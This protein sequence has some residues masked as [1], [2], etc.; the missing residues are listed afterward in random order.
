[1]T[2]IIY[3][4]PRRISNHTNGY[5]VTGCRVLDTYDWRTASFSQPSPVH[6]SYSIL[7]FLRTLMTQNKCRISQFLIRAFERKYYTNSKLKYMFVD[8]DYTTGM[9]TYVPF[10]KAKVASED[11]NVYDYNCKYRQSIKPARFA[12]DIL[13]PRLVKRIGDHHFAEFASIV[14]S[15]LDCNAVTICEENFEDGYAKNSVS[16]CMADKPVAD[17]Y[18]RFDTTL[19]VAKNNKNEMIGRAILW[20]NV[21]FKE[22]T[23]KYM[24]RIYAYNEPTRVA[25]E[26]YALANQI[27]TCR[28]HSGEGPMTVKTK[29]DLK[30]S[31][32]T[33]IPYM[34]TFHSGWVDRQTLSNNHDRKNQK[35]E[36]CSTKGVPEDNGNEVGYV[37][38]PNTYK[39]YPPE[40][41]VTIDD[42]VFFK[43][44]DRIVCIDGTWYK[45]TDKRI[46]YITSAGYQLKINCGICNFSDAYFLK[47]E[48][49]EYTD[50]RD[51][52]V[53][54]IQAHLAQNPTRIEVWLDSEFQSRHKKVEEVHYDMFY[55]H[56]RE[57]SNYEYTFDNKCAYYWS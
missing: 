19:L 55:K 23:V 38:D 2:R 32:S 20:N 7:D 51:G 46:I 29:D 14:K 57:L 4:L 9:F 8:F 37:Y 31:D 56:V 1:M 3:F 16:S 15:Y 10:S 34:D 5:D 30:Y 11:G 6:N 13:N 18:N 26:K 22:N 42:E 53:Y 40:D 41:V 12:K 33:F 49:V 48:L 28:T 39:Y 52:H 21:S 45:R 17:F 44:G 54:T 35:Y 36:L 25:F 50:E 24:D 47:N 43:R 27:I